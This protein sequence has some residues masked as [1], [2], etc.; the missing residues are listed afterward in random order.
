ML[1]A[2]VQKFYP[3]VYTH[4]IAWA[5]E[6][7]AKAKANMKSM[8]LLGNRLDTCVRSCQA[9]QS[10]GIPIG[11]DT[12]WVLSELLLASVDE[13]LAK[14]LGGAKGNR[15]VDDYELY[16]RSAGQ[17]ENALTEL[18]GCLAYY[19]LDLNSDKTAIAPLPAPLDDQWTRQLRSFALRTTKVAQINDLLN[20]FSIAFEAAADNPTDSVLRYAIQR[21]ESETLLKTSWQTYQDLLLQCALGEPGTLQY[22]LAATRRHQIAG[23]AVDKDR[24]QETITQL[25]ARHQPLAHGSEVAWAAWASIALGIQLSTTAVKRLPKSDDP[26]V[27]LLALNASALGLAPGIDQSRWS[28]LMIADEL[29]GKYWLLAYEAL[30]RKWLPSANGVDYVAADTAFSFMKTNRVHFYTAK[31][32]ATTVPKWPRVFSLAKLLGYDL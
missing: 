18:Q 28:K 32:S 6:T 20:Y 10:M 27:P 30:I 14:E 16:F 12:S 24:F 9:G 8:A 1:R 13:A 29:H 2:D 23:R 15:A 11:P 26:L 5:V 25:I 17:A 4:S 21:I 22:V 19:G 7:K 31:S 3:S